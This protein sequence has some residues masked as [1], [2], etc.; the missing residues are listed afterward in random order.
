L[1]SI[2]TVDRW[3]GA[4]V[5][6]SSSAGK[7]IAPEEDLFGVLDGGRDAD[8]IVQDLGG[9]WSDWARYRWILEQLGSTRRP[10]LWVPG[11][12]GAPTREF[13]LEPY[14]L[15]A[16]FPQL[17]GVHRAMEALRRHPGWEA[18]YRLRMA[19]I[20]LQTISVVTTRR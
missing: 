12:T 9:P 5:A 1:V 15:E 14:D 11:P 10:A 7:R 3:K 8:T 17:H 6:N 2:A 13:L 4:R 18:E 19:L 16:S 20:E